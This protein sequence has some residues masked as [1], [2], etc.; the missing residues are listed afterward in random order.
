[1]GF[2]DVPSSRDTTGTRFRAC[3]ARVHRFGNSVAIRSGVA[4]RPVR[5]D[6]RSRAA[7]R[8]RPSVE[9]V[10]TVRTCECGT[11]RPSSP[12]VA[13][14]T[15]W[16]LDHRGRLDD[17]NASRVATRRTSA[18]TVRSTGLP[19][20]DAATRMCACSRTTTPNRGRANNRRSQAEVP[21]YMP[22]SRA[23]RSARRPGLDSCSAGPLS[24]GERVTDASFPEPLDLVDGTGTTGL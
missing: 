1:M 4:Q 8:P 22:S 15:S 11:D 10:S 6:A 7:G 14:P 5:R 18:A 21:H 24:G 16:L 19:D 23:T 9:Q 20:S 12:A 3:S 17:R 13:V 2:R